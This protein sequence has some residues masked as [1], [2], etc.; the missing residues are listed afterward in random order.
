M[1]IIDRSIPFATPWFEVVAKK[2]DGNQSPY[3]SLSMLD[4]V[5]TVALTTEDELLLVR[6]YRPAVERY[7]LEL[8]SGHV[9]C[10]ES[11]E[12]SARREL[13]EET[14]YQ[15]DQIEWLGTLAPDTGRLGNRLW[16]YFAP[17]VKRPGGVFQT[18]SGVELVRCRRE[19]VFDL[20]AN[21][22][23]DHAL[24][25]ATLFL[26]VIKHG[27]DSLKVQPS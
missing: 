7:T 21:V 22:Q 26:A 13:F 15:A 27:S 10:G 12:A 14:G 11:P 16:C 23:L 19:A 24:H 20:I 5:S 9:E 1:K 25:L 8:P 2:T 4:Y 6:Q 3:Y 17:G 18:E